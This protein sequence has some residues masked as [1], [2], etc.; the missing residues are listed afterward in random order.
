MDRNTLGV[1]FAGQFGWILSAFNIRDL[2]CGKRHNVVLFIVPVV[3]VEVVE[4]PSRCTYD[5]DII[6]RHIHISFLFT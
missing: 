3:G 5:D 4:I 2:G 6:L 1:S